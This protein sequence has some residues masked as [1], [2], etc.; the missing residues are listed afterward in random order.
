MNAATRPLLARVRPWRRHLLPRLLPVRGAQQPGAR[1]RRRAVL[2]R[3][4]RD[5]LGPVVDGDDVRRPGR[6]LQRR[7]AF[8]SAPPRPASSRASCCISPTGSRHASG[9]ARRAVLDGQH[10]GWHRRRA[11]V[12]ATAVAARRAA[13]STA[14]SGCS[15]SKAFRPSLLGL[16]AFVYLDDG[17]E[18]PRWL[19]DDEKAWLI[20]TLRRE[21]DAA[22]RRTADDRGAPASSIPAVWHLALVLFLIVTSGIRVQ[23]LPAA[24]R[25]AAVRRI[26]RWPSGSGR[27]SRLRSLRSGMITVAAH[28]DRTGERRWH[29][30]ACAAAIAAWRLASLAATRRCA[31][32]RS[33]RW[34]S[35]RSVCT[36]RR[37]RSG[38]CRRHSSAA[39]ARRRA[40]G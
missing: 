23:L 26:G 19:P 7:C 16:V 12:R 4:H 22:S 39:T 25:E 24:D 9:R 35:P 40:S 14:G 37:R 1:P 32:R 31:D 20:D 15:S 38:R 8:C 33:R 3:P 13:A 28:S 27:R 17:P 34:R 11:A 6:E 10:G 21:R 5:R 36:A 30:A 29:V 2:D 18:K